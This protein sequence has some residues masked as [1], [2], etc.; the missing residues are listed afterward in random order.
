MA[1][2]EITEYDNNN[3]YS[4]ENKEEQQPHAKGNVSLAKESTWRQIKKAFIAD[5]VTSIK[6]FA[7]FDVAIPAI[8]R[9]F[10]EICI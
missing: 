3:S 7:L 1:K 5:E 10:R 2:H 8:K 4:P 9:T 6:H